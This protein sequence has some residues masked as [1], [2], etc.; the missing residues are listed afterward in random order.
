MLLKRTALRGIV[1]GSI[2]LQFRRW[3]RPTVKS[4]GTLLTA[5]G[6]LAI[7][8]VTPVE[9]HAIT[10]SEALAA[11]FADLSA[12]H[13]TLGRGRS[14]EVYRIRLAF[15]G[16]DPRIALRDRPATDSEAREVLEALGRMDA[17]SAIGPWTERTLRVIENRPAERAA[18]L[19]REL[20]IER[21]RFKGNVRKLKALGLTESLEV[22][23]RLTP[24]G[25]DILRR[26][27]GG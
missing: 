1:E 10:D 19:A 8:E 16:P 11:G 14:G 20:G 9:V 25:V 18:D 4:G 22:G 13:D 2:T 12:L 17:R 3:K 21:D 27:P 23:Y 15:D 26:M 24:R 7:I 6:Q 5:V